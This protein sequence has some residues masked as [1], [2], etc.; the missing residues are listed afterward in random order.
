MATYL[1]DID[2]EQVCGDDLQYDP[3]FI[4]LDQAIKG[5]PEQQVGGTIQEAEP[6]NWREIKKSSEALLARTIDLR[7]LIF[8]CRALIAT[9]GYVGLQ[10]GLELIKTLVEHRWSSIHP[11]LDPDDDN[12]PTERV[13]ILMSL[14]DYDTLL[15]PLAQVPLIESKLMGKFNFR[16]ISIAAGK[17]TATKTEKVI[18]QSSIDAAVQDSDADMLIQM[19]TSLTASLEYL[20]QLENFVTDQVGVSDAPSFAELRTF[21]KEARAFVVDWHDTKGI[22]Q[23]VAES[24][25]AQ[26]NSDSDVSVVTSTKSVSGTIN[27]N[28]DVLKALTLVC[29]Y[30]KK[31]EPSS[32]IPLFLERGMRLVGK[33]FM[34]V[35]EDIAPNGVDQAMIFKGKQDGD[36]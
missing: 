36:E 32:P 15:R 11:Q 28:Q 24:E 14:C 22:N 27:N 21:L 6:P 2:P 30:Y 17:T 9:E 29:D 19:L 13:N 34:E 20:N 25:Q 8:Y 18:E 3:D 5:K 4:A 12:D 23:S 16:D 31:H 26:A 33:S 7:I 1:Q 10:Q 35:L